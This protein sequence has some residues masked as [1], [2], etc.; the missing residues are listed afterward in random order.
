M[1]ILQISYVG[2]KMHETWTFYS[3]NMDHVGRYC[4]M[5]S[6]WQAI[7]VIPACMISC[8]KGISTQNH[9]KFTLEYN[10]VLET[11]EAQMKVAMVKIPI[12]AIDFEQVWVKWYAMKGHRL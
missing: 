6:L 10:L 5:T 12:D 9:I 11:L 1:D 7:L 3:S 2:L 8:E 4:H